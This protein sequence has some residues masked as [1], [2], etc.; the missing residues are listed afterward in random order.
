[1][2]FILYIRLGKLHYGCDISI[3]NTK[4]VIT[5]N[6]FTHTKCI[7]TALFLYIKGLCI[8]N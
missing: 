8:I 3:L 7:E 6:N 1:M 5:L 4:Y 2:L